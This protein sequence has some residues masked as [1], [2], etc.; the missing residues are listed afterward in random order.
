LHTTVG[1]QPNAYRKL[2]VSP[3]VKYVDYALP[4]FSGAASSPAVDGD[5]TEWATVPALLTDPVADAPALVDLAEVQVAGIDGG[6]ALALAFQQAAGSNLYLEFGGV[7]SRE[8]EIH[9]EIKHFFRIGAEG[10]SELR[11]GTWQSVGADLFAVVSGPSGMEISISDRLVGDTTTW[12]AWWVRVMA[13]DSETSRW[14]S[15]HAAYFPSVLGGNSIPFRFQKCVQWGGKPSR[16]AQLMMTHYV[17]PPQVLPPDYEEDGTFE[18][19]REHAYQLARF[20]LDLSLSLADAMHYGSGVQTV[21]VSDF[22]TDGIQPFNPLMHDLI[23]AGATYRFLGIN[24][25]NMGFRPTVHFPQGATVET[26]VDFGVQHMLRSTFQTAGPGL[27]G[28]ISLA[29]THQYLKKYIG[30]Q[31]W[32]NHRFYQVQPFTLASDA[33]GPAGLDQMFVALQETPVD[34]RPAAERYFLAKTRAAA[35]ILGEIF[36]PDEVVASWLATAKYVSPAATAEA[37][38]QFFMTALT[39]SLE[40]GDPRTGLSKIMDGYLL[41]AAYHPD[42]GPAVH[43]DEDSDGLPLFGE[44]LYGTSDKNPDTDHDRWSDMAEHVG[45]FDPNSAGQVPGL[46]V[47]DGIFSEWQNLLA[48]KIIVDKGHAGVCERDAD[49]E[50]YAAI[51]TADHLVI[52]AVA[53]D[54]WQGESRARWEAVVDIPSEE[55]VL[56]IVAPNHEREIQIKD[57]TDNRILYTYPLAVPAGGKVSE[58]LV[59]REAMRLKT[60]FNKEQGI[61]IRLRTAYEADEG[62]IFCDE[63]DW[64]APYLK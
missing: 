5:L 35:Q 36:S 63:T 43:K 53:G 44:R 23:S 58:I 20:A 64:F 37:K 21:L 28:T 14:D 3:C 41:S 19:R 6:L 49:I 31:Y 51:G 8:K 55:R 42:F 16:V 47:A 7:L 59:D 29:V 25:V 38:A 11:A 60:P 15:T 4:E 18:V 9:T 54:F 30:P 1:I 61:R 45:G 17:P 24:A 34:K 57:P 26:G 2:D 62:N 40:D 12:P 56:L 10:V 13:Q 46:I 22:V 39:G 48:S 50:F 52:G 33:A 27:L 32:L